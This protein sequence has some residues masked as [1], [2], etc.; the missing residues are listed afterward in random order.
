[1]F[2][3]TLIDVGTLRAAYSLLNR[4]AGVA[5][6]KSTGADSYIIAL[7]TLVEAIILSDEVVVPGV[8]HTSAESLTKLF[9]EAVTYRSFD[10]ADYCQLELEAVDWAV[11]KVSVLRATDA[12]NVDLTTVHGG[13]SDGYLLGLTFGFDRK[14]NQLRPWELSLDEGLEASNSVVYGLDLGHEIDSVL[15]GRLAE[16]VG[17]CRYRFTGESP[18]DTQSLA[19]RLYWI[20][21]RCRCYDMIARLWGLPYAP[22]PFRARATLLSRS[23]DA[24][25][26]A[27]KNPYM[28]AMKAVFDEGRQYIDEHAGAL[29]APLEYSPILPYV[30]S[31]CSKNSEVLPRTYELRAE[32]GPRAI[33]R[34]VAEFNA[35]VSA[36]SIKESMQLGRE[37]ESL[38]RSFKAELGL[39]IGGDPVGLGLFSLSISLPKRLTTMLSDRLLEPVTAALRPQTLFLRNVFRETSTVARLGS[40]FEMLTRGTAAFGTDATQWTPGEISRHLTYLYESSVAAGLHRKEVTAILLKSARRMDPGMAI[41]EAWALVTAV[42]HDRELPPDPSHSS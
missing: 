31:K 6:E 19:Q 23:S 32:R 10:Y 13:S 16:L 9:G 3:S 37:L 29:L 28:N 5:L 22:H 33:R 11:S 42:I 7:S 21:V 39:P 12:F 8:P 2:N 25:N 15:D 17:L 14:K 18:G 38:K 26:V 1:M 30:L 4:E 20:L 40:K 35:A 27:L 24:S 34:R 36:G 41:G